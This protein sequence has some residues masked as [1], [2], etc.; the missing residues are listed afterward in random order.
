MSVP[1]FEK[2]FPIA[3]NVKVKIIKNVC[4]YA[5][6]SISN[7]S[8]KGGSKDLK[9]QNRVC[10]ACKYFTPPDPALAKYDA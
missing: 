4:A 6:C 7:S 5:H 3:E 9:I 8:N 2:L 1:T 10:N